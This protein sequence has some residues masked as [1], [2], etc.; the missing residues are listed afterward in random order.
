MS[1]KLV[2]LHNRILCLARLHRRTEARL[3]DHLQ[4]AEKCRLFLH[5]GH[6]SL[7]RYVCDELGFSEA[8]TSNLITVA[9]K[10]REI[11]ELKE[12]IRKGN[13]S[14]SKLRKVC[15]VIDE[16][17]QQEWIEAVKTCT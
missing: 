4:E 2:E 16:K 1:P 8:M 10:V 12:E 9:R 17:N 14:V 6:S 13:L 5:R 11:P 15:P 7:F 3:I